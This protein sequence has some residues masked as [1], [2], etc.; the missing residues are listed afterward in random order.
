[1][2]EMIIN[3]FRR[4]VGYPPYKFRIGD[5]VE[6]NYHE[7]D[8]SQRP[9]KRISTKE[10]VGRVYKSS[11][12]KQHKKVDIG[13]GFYVYREIRV[14]KYELGFQEE[15]PTSVARIQDEDDLT[16]AERFHTKLADLL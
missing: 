7:Y 16:L 13:K 15:R 4:C 3:L 14:N 8:Y 9:A 12:H 2:K 1:M 11:S 6:L 5:I 10:I